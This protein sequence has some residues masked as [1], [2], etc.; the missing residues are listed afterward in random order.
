MS[1]PRIGMLASGTILDGRM[2]PAHQ[3]GQQPHYH[4]LVELLGKKQDIAINVQSNVPEPG[5]DPKMASEVLYVVKNTTPPNAQQLLA[6]KPG[7]IFIK[8]GDGLGID[9]VRTKGLVS[10]DEMTLLDV[11]E[12]TP[13]SMHTKIDD[14]VARAKKE[15]HKVWIFCQLF[16]NSGKPNPFW[17]FTPDQGGHDIHMDQGDDGPHKHE[18]GTF[19]D[20]GIFIQWADGT[21]TTILIAF[22]TQSWNTDNQGDPV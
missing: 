4:W 6:L 5:E 18:N 2:F 9:Y 8:P 20:G 7:V 13:N 3:P 11:N 14:V 10:R 22:Q 1:L 17:G 19:Q 12:A 21:W 15:Q 16:R